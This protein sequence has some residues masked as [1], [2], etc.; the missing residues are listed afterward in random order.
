[1]KRY[2]VLGFNLDSTAA[3]SAQ[4]ISDMWQPDAQETHRADK[5]SIRQHFIEQFGAL[6]S[7]AKIQN[8]FDLGGPPLSVVAFHNTFL[9]QARDAF[10]IGAYY[11]ALTGICALGERVF[12]DLILRL[13]DF[14]TDT[15]EYKRVYNKSSFDKWEMAI[16]VLETWHVVLPDVVRE[17]E[18]LARIKNRT[19]HFHHVTDRD[20]R[21]LALE[22]I[23]SFSR[24]LRMQFSGFGNQPWF[25]PQTPGAS[26]IK[27]EAETQ[28][29]IQVV[30]LPNSV[31]VGPDHELEFSENLQVSVTDRDDYEAIE[32]SDE[33]FARLFTNRPS[34]RHR[35]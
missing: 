13:R 17:Y 21:S 28:P 8:L 14:Y 16:D 11:P 3:L 24:I 9:R 33:E 26:F 34:T 18:N 30:Y 6:N 15:P 25:I 31:L 4:E 10:V 23:D 19:M 7:D 32:I 2:R 12:N 27:K 35:K 5:E 1:M 22:A 29:F 20:A